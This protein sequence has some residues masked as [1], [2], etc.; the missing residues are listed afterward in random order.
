[1]IPCMVVWFCGV[2]PHVGLWGEK[3]HP[4]LDGR[5]SCEQVRYTDLSER[6]FVKCSHILRVC[7]MFAKG[8]VIAL[9]LCVVS[10]NLV[11]ISLYP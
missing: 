8:A 2:H 3:V 4:T 9:S 6:E 11:L 5:K 7:V 1:M 10:V